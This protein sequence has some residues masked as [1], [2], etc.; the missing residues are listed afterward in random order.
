[1]RVG[2]SGSLDPPLLGGLEIDFCLPAPEM[3]R[4]SAP[5]VGLLSKERENFLNIVFCAEVDNSLLSLTDKSTVEM[6]FHDESYLTSQRLS[7]ASPSTRPRPWTT[8]D[9]R[10]RPSECLAFR[11]KFLPFSFLSLVTPLAGLVDPEA[12]LGLGGGQTADNDGDKVEVEQS[13]CCF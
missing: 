12:V 5:G 10:R 2:H 11:N 13:R 6:S 9:R 3:D 4:F 7:A 1:M 8:S